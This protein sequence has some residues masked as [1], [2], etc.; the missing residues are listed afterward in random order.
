MANELL[1]SSTTESYKKAL[2]SFLSILRELRIPKEQTRLKWWDERRA[3]IFRAFFSVNTPESNLPEV[4]HA[5]W[6]NT[7]V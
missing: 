7:C 4:I 1:C 6:E 2:N 5:G 3:Y